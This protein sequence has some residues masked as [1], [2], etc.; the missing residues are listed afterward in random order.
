MIGGSSR[1]RGAG[2][3][4]LIRLFLGLISVSAPS[5]TVSEGRAPRTDASTK[6]AS[7]FQLAN[8]E[9]FMKNQ[10]FNIVLLFY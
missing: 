2:V 6:W 5:S 7:L 1:R 9:Y 10:V 3:G 8:L 4:V